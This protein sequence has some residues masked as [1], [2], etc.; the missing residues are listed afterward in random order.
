M[1]G[2][3]DGLAIAVGGERR[4][5]LT[6]QIVT[7]F[8]VVVDLAVEHQDVPVGLA[9][10]PPAQRLVGMGDVDDRQAVETED[11]LTVSPG[12]GLVGPAMAHEVR[13][14]GHGVDGVFGDRAGRVSN[15]GKQSAHSA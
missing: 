7:Q 3:D 4:A 9:R 8:Q 11:N 2:G 6:A 13:R 1:I 10:R 5:E 12:A 14:S 15:Q